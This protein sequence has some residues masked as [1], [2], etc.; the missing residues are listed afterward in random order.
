MPVL[1]ATR[2]FKRTYFCY[3][4]LVIQEFLEE[5]DPNFPV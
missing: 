3:L 1:Q 4:L 5:C 2:H